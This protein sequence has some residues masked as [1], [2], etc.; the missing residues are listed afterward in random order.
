[1]HAGAVA[2][3]GVL[4]RGF[5]CVLVANGVQIDGIYGWN[6]PAFTSKGDIVVANFIQNTVHVVT[7]ATGAMLHTFGAHGVGPMQFD[8]PFGVCVSRDDSVLIADWGNHRIQ[9]VANLG[10]AGTATLLG[11]GLLLQPAYTAFTPSEDAIIVR[12]LGGPNRIVVL[13]RDGTSI[14]RVLPISAD[15]PIG[16]FGLAVSRSGVVAAGANNQQ[17][18]LVCSVGGEWKRKIDTAQLPALP[19]NLRGVAFDS[20]E[21]L[22]TCSHGAKAFVRIAAR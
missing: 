4:K 1:M 11:V 9:E 13:A 19:A 21:R 18:V 6:Q 5:R 14:L 7:G 10:R 16:L 17:W 20:Q 3:P 2:S 15:D 8:S 22:I 12:Q